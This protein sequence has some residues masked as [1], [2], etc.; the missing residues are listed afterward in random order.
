MNT[1]GLW[2]TSSLAK[3]LDFCESESVK[4]GYSD[5][6]VAMRL[7]SRYCIDDPAYAPEQSISRRDDTI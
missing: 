6:K 3:V 5:N 7:L 4:V 1:R 2:V